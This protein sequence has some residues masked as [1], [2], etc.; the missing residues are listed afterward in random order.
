MTQRL[1]PHRQVYFAVERD[2][3]EHEGIGRLVLDEDG[4]AY[5]WLPQP[6]FGH[7]VIRL[8]KDRLEPR[9]QQGS[10]GPGFPYYVYGNPV[11]L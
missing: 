4:Q 9:Q 3:L 2:G 11:R 6:L 8:D 10:Y 7:Y 5:V 1:T